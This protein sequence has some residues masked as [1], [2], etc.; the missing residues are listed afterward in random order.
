MSEFSNLAKDAEQYAK[1]HPD[2]VHK[3][4][5]AAEDKLGMGGQQDQGDQQRQGDAQDQGENQ[6]QQ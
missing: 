1:D 4:E 2:Q 6:Q 3:A 5:H